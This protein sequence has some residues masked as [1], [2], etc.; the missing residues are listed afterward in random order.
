M[1]QLETAQEVGTTR[2]NVS[3]IEFRARRKIRK[4]EE[5]LRVYESTLTDHSVEVAKGTRT[6]EIPRIVL[7]EGDRFGVHP[8]TNVVDIIRMVRGLEPPCLK[9]GRTRR[10]LKFSFNQKGELRLVSGR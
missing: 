2:A 4:A 1:S 10:E 8:Q 7:S 5:T 6:F 9:N 3:M